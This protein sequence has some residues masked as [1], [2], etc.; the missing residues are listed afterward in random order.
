M[1]SRPDESLKMISC[2]NILTRTRI[3]PAPSGQVPRKLCELS[4][5]HPRTT[6]RGFSFARV[7]DALGM[8]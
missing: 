4:A 2:N 1:L 8:V 5:R 7:T 6:P 3:T